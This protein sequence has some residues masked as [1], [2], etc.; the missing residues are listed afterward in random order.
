MRLSSRDEPRLKRARTVASR[1]LSPQNDPIGGRGH[2][3]PQ[4]FERQYDAPPTPS[5]SQ[6]KGSPKIRSEDTTWREHPIV[7][8]FGDSSSAMD[9]ARRVSPGHAFPACLV[10]NL[11]SYNIEHPTNELYV[12]RRKAD[13]SLCEL[14]GGGQ[15]SRRFV[16][17]LHLQ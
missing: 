3:S 6:A 12:P 4:S 17:S 1:S 5:Y 2:R 9:I 11:R 13:E 10:L 8:E 7:V 14:N 16:T 15:G